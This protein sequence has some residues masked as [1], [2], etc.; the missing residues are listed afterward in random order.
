M[1]VWLISY[2][3]KYF[4]L[5]YCERKTLL[6]G[7]QIQLLQSLKERAIVNGGNFFSAAV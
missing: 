1:F 3:R 6:N 5:I 2:D 7:W 4:W